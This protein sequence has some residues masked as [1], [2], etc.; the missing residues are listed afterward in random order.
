M[1]IEDLKRENAELKTANLK[2]QDQV[3]LMQTIFDSLSEAVVATNLEGEFL[4]ANPSAQ[5]MAGMAP[6]EGAPEEWSETYGTFYP[7]KTTPVPSTE[8]PLYKAMQGETTD[9]VKLVLRNQNRQE[10][11]FVSV[12]GRPLYDE[13]GSLVGGVIAMRDVTQLE[14][15]T[16]QLEA[17]IHDLQTQNNLL[18]TVLNSISN[19]VIVANA[20]GEFL[21]FNPVAEEIVGIGATEGD[22]EEWEHVY[23]TFHPDKVTPFPSTE[24]PLYKAIQGETVNDVE[25]FIRNQN[26]PNG[27]FISVGGRPL[28]DQSGSLI[29]G[30]VIFHDITQ[31]KRSAE[32]LEASVSDLQGQNSLMDAIFNSISDGV[33]VANQDGKYVLFNRT[34]RNMA[35]Q[36]IEDV[37][38]SQAPEKFGLFRPDTEE[39]YPID[40]LPLARA[41]KGEYADNVEILIRNPQVPDGVYASISG[42][43]IYNEKGVVNGAVAAI[44]D[45]TSLKAAEKQLQVTNSQLEAQSQLLQSIFNSI[46]DGVFVADE[47]GNIIMANP[48]ARQMAELLD[49]VVSPD[50]WS[51]EYNFFYLDKVTPFPIDELPIM[52]AIRGEFVDNVEMFV[53]T[54]KAPDG[55]YLNVNGRPLK[56]SD[57]NYTGGVVVFRDVTDKVKAEEALAQAFAQGRL[58]IVDTILHNIGNAINSVSV[59][60]DTI[61]HQLTNDKLTARLTALANVIEQHQDNF[62]DYVKNDPQGQKVLPFILTLASDFNLVKGQWE[63]TVERIRN[64]TGHI[65]DIIRTQNSYHGAST[66]RKDINLAVAISDAIKILQDSIEKRQIQTEIDCGD[67]PKE[68]RIQESQFHQM[69]VNVIKNSVEAIDELGTLGERHEAPRIQIRS[70]IL[71]ESLCIDITDNGIGI[72]PEDLERIFSAG[73]T[74]KEH[75]SGL[76]LHSS[77]NF[78]IG[79]GGKIHACSDGKGKGATV[80]ILLRLSSIQLNSHENNEE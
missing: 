3:K 29:G 12:S 73:F 45:I 57:D 33:I 78:V 25:V 23:G 16:A 35:G 69:L 66:T 76:G 68:I 18:D 62:S 11:V 17:T 13:T 63:Q 61:H 64:R 42:R 67:A 6:V 58:E 46:S 77:A 48:R 50:V 56:D 36:D 40:E 65:V 53:N 49:F 72:E 4:V 8:L 43:P 21:Y 14:R 55:I 31:L 2:L 41:V 26:R 79:C 60:I 47:S 27:V 39:F 71:E 70:R 32:Q 10:G 59:G 28:H 22:P 7:D 75:G 74:S 5:E 80:R 34:A 51:K 1:S 37:H 54:D 30:V 38:I 52:A 19:G 15:I 24:L 9:D 44:R 20:E